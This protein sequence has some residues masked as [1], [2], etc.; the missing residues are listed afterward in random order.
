[1]GEPGPPTLKKGLKRNYLEIGKVGGSPKA[2]TSG[3]VIGLLGV[4]IAGAVV[5]K[6]WEKKKPRGKR[7][8]K[9]V[10]AGNYERGD[11]SNPT[12]PS[13]RVRPV[14]G[15]KICRKIVEKKKK[16]RVCRRRGKKKWEI[17]S[18]LKL[19]ASRL[20]LRVEKRQPTGRSNGKEQE[21][22]ITPVKKN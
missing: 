18:M 10:E 5:G 4:T 3:E 20:L 9:A 15:T 1:L 6:A 13:F 19:K 21:S 2:R 22:A 14:L 17:N 7:C 11:R 12:S 8:Y 16:R